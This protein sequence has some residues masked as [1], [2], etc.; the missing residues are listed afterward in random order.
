MGGGLIDWGL[1]ASRL[2]KE[3][4]GAVKVGEPLKK[5]TTW[6]VGGPADL[7]VTPHSITDL[8]V[9]VQYSHLYGLPLTIIGNG[10]NLLALDGGVRGIVIK[11]RGGL[12]QLHIQDELVQ[13]EAGILLS[14]LAKAAAHQNLSGLEFT[15][16]IPATVGGA[17]VM[18]AGT[19]DGVMAEVLKEGV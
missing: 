17:T 11:T 14:F 15:A 13:A 8:Q 2:Q 6:R 1:L 5:H 19:G 7:L 4:Q 12:Q 18:N 16:G 9:C 10:S 3:I